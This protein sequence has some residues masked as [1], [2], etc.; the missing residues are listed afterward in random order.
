MNPLYTFGFVIGMPFD[1]I[2]RTFEFQ[3]VKFLTEINEKS[4]KIDV[5]FDCIYRNSWNSER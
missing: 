4:T 3:N 2:F 1:K 5:I